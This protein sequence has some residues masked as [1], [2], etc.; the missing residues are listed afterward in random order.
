MW[1]LVTMKLWRNEEKRKSCQL[2]QPLSRGW[3]GFGRK[4][5]E[6]GLDLEVT[7]AQRKAASCTHSQ[8]KGE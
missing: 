7:R 8:T 4:M 1:L 5:V 3:L 6:P 2:P